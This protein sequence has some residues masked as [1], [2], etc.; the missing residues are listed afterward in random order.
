MSLHR[1][2]LRILFFAAAWA[3]GPAFADG[4]TVVGRVEALPARFLSETV[5]YLRDAKPPDPPPAP[6]KVAID[7]RGLKFTPH[8]VAITVGDA[9]EFPNGDAVDHNVFTPDNEGYNLGMIKPNSAGAYTF[10]QPGVYTQ[11]CSV[12]SEMLAYVFVGTT[13]YQAVVEPNG[14]FKIEHVPPGTFKLAVWNSHLKAAEQSVTVVEG[15]ST[16][17]N[18]SLKR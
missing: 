6:R 14:T 18:F 17:A 11:L 5:V 10:R 8:V 15:K 12:H 3:A 16:E 4:G 13:P 9:V 2:I 7:Q 1:S